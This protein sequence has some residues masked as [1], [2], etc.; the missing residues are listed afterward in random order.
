MDFVAPDQTGADFRLSDWR[1]SGVL[2]IFL[3]GD[4]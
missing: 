4:W 2:L 1:G 3:R